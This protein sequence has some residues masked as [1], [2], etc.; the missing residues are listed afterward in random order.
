[1]ERNEQGRRRRLMCCCC[2]AE[3][4][5]RLKGAS[6]G[7]ASGCSLQTV[8]QERRKG[9]GCVWN[10]KRVEWRWQRRVSPATRRCSQDSGRERIRVWEIWKTESAAAFA[11]AWTNGREAAAVSQEIVR[12][13]MKGSVCV[14]LFRV[15]ERKM[16]WA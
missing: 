7:G 11:G 16:N 8:R 1:M 15:Y 5:W 4:W 3:R 2:P 14:Q 10:R 13:R 9:S 12:D 6:G